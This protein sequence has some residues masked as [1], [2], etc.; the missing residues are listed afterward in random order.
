MRVRGITM[1]LLLTM[2]AVAHAQS[3]GTFELTGFGRYTRFDDT[4]RLQEG[5][6]G[7][8]SLGFY[9]LRNLAIEA[10]GAYSA[11]H[12]N[13]TRSSVSSIP[14]RGRLTYHVPLGGYAS[15][16]R[17]GAGYLHK[18]YREDVSFDD[19]G[20]TGVFGI[21]WGLSPSF[22]IRVD[23][24]ADYVRRPDAARADEYINWGTQVGLSLRFGGSS[25]RHSTEAQNKPDP[26]PTT[27]PAKVVD[28]AGGVAGQMDA[29]HDGVNDEADR[30]ADT[31]RG[32]TVD[33]DGCSNSQ[34]DD[35]RDG[36]LNSDDQCPNS[37]ADERTDATGCAEIQRDADKDGVADATDQCPNSSMGEL[38]DSRG[39]SRDSDTDGVPD[40][41]DRC[42]NTPTG[43]PAD[44]NGCPVLFQKGAKSVIL[45]GVTFRS[46]KA[47]LTPQSREV[48][49]DIATQL[50]ANPSYRVQ[51]SGHSDNV[52]SR[53]SNLR[54]SLARART[55]ESF[56]IGNGVPPAQVRS[57]GF[58]PDVPIASNKTAAGRAKNRR[59]ELNRTN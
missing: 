58:G 5:G 22:G 8:G 55:V 16:I 47:M 56:L 34:K 9:L 1:V 7:G 4:L 31:F 23:G 52:G 48:L 36:V 10:E 53:A 2:G 14:L 27:P 20:F 49:R 57:K 37:S 38:V 13:L 26:Q 45:K 11:T 44:E 51:I 42:P 12:S 40:G 32:E 43:Q 17:L 29:D 28:E 50:V 54:L 19:D 21:R 46:G 24:T 30:C 3:P 59:V 6:G 35:D 33:P 15:A 18:L 25:H 41:R 39:C